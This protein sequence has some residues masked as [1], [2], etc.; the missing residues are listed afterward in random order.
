MPFSGFQTAAFSLT[1][2]SHAIGNG[3]GIV[4]PACGLFRHVFYYRHQFA[5]GVASSPEKIGSP[6]GILVPPA[7]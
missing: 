4:V 2:T 3:R 7:E 6:T 5:V 1:A